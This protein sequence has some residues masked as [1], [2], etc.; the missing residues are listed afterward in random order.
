MKHL[1]LLGLL[2]TAPC[3]AVHNSICASSFQGM[4]DYGDY[5]TNQKHLSSYTEQQKKVI[6]Q[7]IQMYVNQECYTI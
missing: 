7:L 2:I 4:R 6:F 3:F 1:V 5:V